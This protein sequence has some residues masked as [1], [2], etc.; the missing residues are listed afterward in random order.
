MKAAGCVSIS[1][2]IESGSQVI[3]NEIGKGTNVENNRAVSKMTWEVGLIPKLFMMIGMPS[4]T[5]ETLRQSVAFC[6]DVGSLAE[7]SIATPIPGTPLCAMAH[8][9]GKVESEP[10]LVESWD[11]WLEGVLI[12]MTSMT[13]EELL[14]GKKQAEKEILNHIVMRHW[15]NLLGTLGMFIRVNGITDLFVRPI[16]FVRILLRALHGKGVSGKKCNP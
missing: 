5:K 7:F 8:N 6:K 16:H 15:R 9:M 3:L 14:D 11:N 13:D 10:K 12:N 2:G 1:L 4:E